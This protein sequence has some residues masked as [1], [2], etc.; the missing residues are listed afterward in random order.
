MEFNNYLKKIQEELSKKI[1]TTN[2]LLNKTE[3]Q[4]DRPLTR[5]RKKDL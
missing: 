4:K 3:L 1:Q 2:N 5:L